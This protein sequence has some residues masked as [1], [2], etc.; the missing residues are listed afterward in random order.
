MS[1][2][3]KGVVDPGSEDC[4]GRL[5][6]E[7]SQRSKRC[8]I[9]PA[10]RELITCVEGEYLGGTQAVPDLKLNSWTATKAVQYGEDCRVWEF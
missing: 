9:D 4:W 10:P 6:Q 5:R 7:C 1:V 8:R 3:C 2:V